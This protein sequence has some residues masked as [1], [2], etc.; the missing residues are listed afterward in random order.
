MVTEV[1]TV[2]F[3]LALPRSAAYVDIP[4]AEKQCCVL[5]KDIYK[6]KNDVDHVCF[7]P[8]NN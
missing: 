2:L 1:C 4:R 5:G 7:S 3:Y 6:V 8:N